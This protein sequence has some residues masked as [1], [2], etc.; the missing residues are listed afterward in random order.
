MHS[1]RLLTLPL[2]LSLVFLQMPVRCGA[3]AVYVNKYVTGPVRDGTTWSTAF[4]GLQQAINDANTPSGAEI[5]VAAG[6]YTGNI[7]VPRGL[8]IY[9]G[10]AG[11]ET[12][13]S[14][15]QLDR[16][17]TILDGGGAGIV[18]DIHGTFAHPATL[19]GFSVV[20]GN[21]LGDAGGIRAV[22]FVTITNNTI[23]ANQAS[24]GAGVFV[25][26]YSTATIVDN[27]IRFNSAFEGG[28]VYVDEAGKAT[29][30]GNTII[31]NVAT[32]NSCG[33]GG[34]ILVD[35][36][37]IA[38]VVENGIYYNR[39]DGGAGVF[40]RLGTATIANNTISQNTASDGGGVFVDNGTTVIANNA[41]T[42]N[43][44]IGASAI[45]ASGPTTIANDTITANSSTNPGGGAV[46]VDGAATIENTIVAFNTSGVGTWSS[47]ALT[48]RNNDVFGNIA[49]NYSWQ[50]QP[51]GTNGNISVD[52]LL[53][54]IYHDV[55]IQ[56]NSPC[57][58]AGDDSAVSPADH[59]AYGRPRIQGA[60]VDIGS[61]ESD[62]T[63]WSRFSTTWYVSM[64]ASDHYS[65]SSWNQALQTVE[66]A[67]ARARGGD[68]IWVA[69]GDYT[70][71]TAIPAGVAL[72]GGFAGTETNRQ[73]RD[74]KAN[75]AYLSA[76]D[77]DKDVVTCTAYG[78]TV[79]GFNIRFG[80]CG[81]NVSAGAT[82]ANSMLAYNRGGV[83]VDGSGTIA[84]NLIVSNSGYGVQT[85]EFAEPSVVGNTVVGNGGG[86]Y[87]NGYL[88]ARVANNIIALNNN[89]G[90]YN[91]GGNVSPTF[92][93]NDVFGNTQGDY[94]GYTPP[95]DMGNI[96]QDPLIADQD[97]WDYHILAGSP[98]VDAGDDSY[99]FLG[100]TDRDGNP[101]RQGAHTD[102][103]AYEYP[104][105]GYFSLADAATAL[106][107]AGG[108]AGLDQALTTRL[109]V[110]PEGPSARSVDILDA[111]RIARKAVGLDSN[112]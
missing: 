42:A 26:K 94:S 84:N 38:T 46:C 96:S 31:G 61:D 78:A 57:V 104:A 75:T 33:A 52:P 101:R 72:Y 36:W 41:I 63:Q 37:G 14:Q 35:E 13:R 97:R 62:G 39:A 24:H 17:A 5:W 98:C 80:K 9:G 1:Y 109:N 29:I 44:A 112:P 27:D 11:T 103:G 100:E 65:G 59:D 48:L 47:D 71:R 50:E 99:V 10:F 69:A 2:A 105:P 25:A 73:Q 40:V 111:V 91:P 87:I 89:Y 74:L 79:D 76:S 30:A 45:S 110:V 43:S 54:N 56:P 28:G 81:A 93:H 82:L 12:L 20:N 77:G 95:T 21:S 53:N 107:S 58:D 106:R 18:V 4:T 102:I 32:G 86:I 90:L 88:F 7:T 68:E 66:A 108:C 83:Y 19:D 85:G 34:A 15:R 8:A 22:G 92:T 64:V 23:A 60:H 70:L 6:T 16:S 55:H 3:T 67:L 51:I 49:F